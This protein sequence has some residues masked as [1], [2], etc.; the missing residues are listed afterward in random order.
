M[1]ASV[2]LFPLLLISFAEPLGYNWGYLL[3]GG[4]I[5]GQ[6]SLYTATVAKRMREA[7]LFALMLAVLLGFLYILL[8][9]ETYSLLAGSLALFAVLSA[10]ML[11][12]RN[13][14]WSAWNTSPTK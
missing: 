6:A 8:S 12:T 7:G 3:G 11:L 13:I 1:G 4:L 5:I 2:S 10:V 14:D 9:M